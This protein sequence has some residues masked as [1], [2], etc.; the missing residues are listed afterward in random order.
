MSSGKHLEVKVL[1]ALN[2]PRISDDGRDPT[3]FVRVTIQTGDDAQQT[4]QQ[5]TSVST[6][7][8]CNPTW[9]EVLL[10]SSLPSQS[11][12]FVK[13]EIFNH[14]MF[15]G[16]TLLGD[17]TMP[18][19]V[20]EESSNS[21][22]TEV[23]CGGDSRLFLQVSAKN[24]ADFQHLLNDKPRNPSLSPPRRG[25]EQQQQQFRQEEQNIIEQR[26]I[27]QQIEV[28]QEKTYDDD[29]IEQKVQDSPAAAATTAAEENNNNNENT[30]N[31]YLINDLSEFPEAKRETLVKC[32]SIFDV[33]GN[34]TL[35]PQESLAAFLTFF[36]S[37]SAFKLR[38][39]I[40]E[41][42]L[43]SDGNLDLLEFARIAIQFI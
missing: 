23:S 21:V 35:S 10:F 8:N 3:A 40:R 31:Q 20:D 26:E 39:K 41:A 43:N 18:F 14:D 6:G 22:E 27:V 38:N 32:F 36:P 9:R 28:F 25:G 13:I 19:G 15:D 33:D 11:S 37:M 7:K 16:D 34:G 1:K 5:S 42:D 12:P 29:N 17:A 4:E 30:G 2:L 24:P